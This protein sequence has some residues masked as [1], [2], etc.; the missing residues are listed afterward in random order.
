MTIFNQSGQTVGH[1]VNVVQQSDREM[2]K[3]M[4]K[5]VG[6]EFIEPDQTQLQV[7]S[8]YSGFYTQFTF[9]KD[10]DLQTMGAYE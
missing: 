5:R 10:G 7:E 6:I 8:G 1:Q 2:L 3:A 4:F 9:N